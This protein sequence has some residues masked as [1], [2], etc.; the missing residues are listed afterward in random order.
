MS[1]ACC[2]GR[3]QTLPRAGFCHAQQQR[4]LGAGSRRCSPGL[5]GTASASRLLSGV[6]PLKDLEKVVLEFR[7]GFPYF[8]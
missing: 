7:S 3:C 1:S 6:L 8:S 5:L 2:K 4:S